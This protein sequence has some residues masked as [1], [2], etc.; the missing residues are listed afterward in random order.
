MT[1][2]QVFERI[3]KHIE[4]PELIAAVVR[5]M[6]QDYIFVPRPRETGTAITRRLGRLV[7]DVIRIEHKIAIGSYVRPE[8]LKS[9]LARIAALETVCEAYGVNFNDQDQVAYYL[10][11]GIVGRS[12]GTYT[13]YLE[14]HPDADSYAY[15]P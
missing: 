9:A 3:G 15:T 10:R 4:D 12:R 14:E 7:S 6:E 2:A 1:D 11:R 13:G 8:V 5:E